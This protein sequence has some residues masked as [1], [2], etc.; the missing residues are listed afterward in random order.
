MGAAGVPGPAGPAGAAG[1]AGPAG[2]AGPAGPAGPTGSSAVIPFNC[3]LTVPIPNTSSVGFGSAGQ[4]I[5]TGTDVTSTIYFTAPRS[6]TL[7]NLYVSVQT[8][9]TVVAGMTFTAAI[10]YAPFNG[11]AIPV[12]SATTIIVPLTLPAI[13]GTFAAGN[14]PNTWPVSQ[15]DYIGLNFT[16]PSGSYVATFAGGMEIV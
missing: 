1:P 16:S 12:F 15:G 7:R 3:T 9:N 10:Q 4:G 5:P 8:S 13:T 14:S 2:V 11:G 6:G